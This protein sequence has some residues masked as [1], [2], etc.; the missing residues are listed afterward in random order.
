MK[1]LFY[2]FYVLLKK[3]EF[4]DKISS[5]ISYSFHLIIN[6]VLLLLYLFDCVFD[7]HVSY[8]FYFIVYVSLIISFFLLSLIFCFNFEIRKVEVY[9]I[10]KFG[11]NQLNK[12]QQVF[13]ITLLLILLIDLSLIANLIIR[14]EG[15]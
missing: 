14:V 7:I 9:L 4:G 5:S 2:M 3:L 11:I 10:N 1:L 13:N 15:L 8:V 12:Y 6:I